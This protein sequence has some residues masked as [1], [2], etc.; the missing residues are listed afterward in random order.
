MQWTCRSDS[1]YTL[2]ELMVVIIVLSILTASIV[3]Q[4]GGTYKDSLLRA[5]GRKVVSVLRLAHS[6]AVTVGHVHRVR[7]DPVSLRF[8]L[9]S[10]NSEGEFSPVLPVAGCEG[11]LEGKV[12][13]QVMQSIQRGFEL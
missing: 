12:L 7:L 1:G 10:R 6:Q 9:E 2:I 11:T 5:N 8:S 4:F 13:V 3:P